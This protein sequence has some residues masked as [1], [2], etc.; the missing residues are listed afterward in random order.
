MQKELRYQ[1]KIQ[2]ISDM[3]RKKKIHA[4][5]PYFFILFLKNAIWK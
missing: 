4:I 2:T 3:P 5:S 1:V